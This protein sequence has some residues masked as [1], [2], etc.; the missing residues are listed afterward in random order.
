MF[1]FICCT[2]VIAVKSP[3]EPPAQVITVK[4]LSVD[5]RS[6]TLADEEK[7]HASSSD[8]PITRVVNKSEAAPTGKKEPPTLMEKGESS[9]EKEEKSTLQQSLD[10]IMAGLE[11]RRKTAG[12]PDDPMVRA[13]DVH[14]HVQCNIASSPVLPIGWT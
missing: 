12:R 1:H 14:V 8:K 11:T 6:P 13:K 3:T 9:T 5:V 2:E 4:P 10:K 7:E